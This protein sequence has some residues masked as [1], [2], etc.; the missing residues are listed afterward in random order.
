MNKKLQITIILSGIIILIVLIV[1]SSFFI[2]RYFLN[3]KM[4]EKVIETYSDKNI[5]ERLEDSTNNTSDLALE[6]DGEIVIGVIKI[7]KINFEGLVYEG[8]SLDT[9]EK[10][11][12]H[13][14]NT[15]NLNGNVG[16]AAHNTRK[17]WAKLHTLKEGDTI[18]YISYLGS[19]DYVVKNVSIIDET[20]WINL[21][22]TLYNQL[23]LITCVLNKKE[24][25]LCVQAVE[26]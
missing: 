9:L 23:T 16:L 7:D 25:R 5:Q 2:T 4:I 11:V 6:I 8:T 21:E 17:F 12:G 19:K 18:S 3:K 14:E 24:K 1:I 22:D 13:F 26:I 15:P 10:G 20:N